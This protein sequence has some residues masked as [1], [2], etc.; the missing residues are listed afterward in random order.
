MAVNGEA[1]Y[2]RQECESAINFYKN[3]ITYYPDFTSAIFKLSKT[4]YKIQDFDNAI[5]YLKK[6]LLIDPNQEQSEKCWVLF[7]KN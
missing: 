7:M 1:E 6:G 2:R 4:F 3:A 5:I